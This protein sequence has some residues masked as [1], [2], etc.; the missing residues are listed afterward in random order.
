MMKMLFARGQVG[1]V[2]TANRIVMAPMTRS[3]ALPGGVPG[4]LTV[5]Y[6][7][8]RASAGLIVTE[9][10]APSP[11]GLGY[12]R[13]PAIYSEEQIAGWKAVT[14][15][16]HNQGGQIAVQLMH[17]GR[18]AHPL[19]QPD[20]ARIEGPSPVAAAGS[21]WTDDAGKQDLP[22]PHELSPS[23]IRQVV[24]DYAQAVRN[25]RSAGFDAVEIHAANG[26]LPNQFLSP[27]SNQRTDD[28]G[29]SVERRARFVLEVVDAAITAWSA[30]RIGVRI[31]PGGTFNDMLDDNPFATYTYLTTQ[32]SARRVAF[33]HIAAQQPFVPAE[34]EFDAFSELR[35][36]FA[37]SLIA[38]GG[39]TLE[40]AERMLAT[41]VADLVAFG[42]PFIANP[43]LPRRLRFSW[44]LAQPDASTLYSSG[45]KGYT[46]Y[47][48]YAQEAAAGD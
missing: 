28:F 20:G 1:A 7:A 29:G 48:A 43:D 3:R 8:Q 23:E 42:R 4:P 18:I 25:A 5:E 21:M 11:S 36:R 15:A 38:N 14:D 24:E 45:S 31:S 32:L 13:T 47:P 12:A 10:V 19:N 46:D 39:L 37:G 22:V 40:S 6:Y 9:G 16:V 30:D 27:N 17:V 26:Y 33:L 41:N 44:P 35:Q 2:E 34:K